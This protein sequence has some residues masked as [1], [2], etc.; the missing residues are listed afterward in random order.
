MQAGFFSPA[1]GVGVWQVVDLGAAYIGY[2]VLGNLSIKLNTVKPRLHVYV[3]IV[4]IY[5]HQQ[6]FRWLT[7]DLCLAGRILPGVEGEA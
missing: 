4:V 6:L 5:A 3:D 1:E 7:Q 2:I